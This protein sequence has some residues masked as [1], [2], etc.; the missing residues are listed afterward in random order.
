[1]VAQNEREFTVDCISR[2]EATQTM[3]VSGELAK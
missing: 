3:I 2:E 1:M